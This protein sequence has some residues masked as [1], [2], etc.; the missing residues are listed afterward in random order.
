[1]KSLSLLLFF[2]ATC[3]SAQTNQVTRPAP[4]VFLNVAVI[5]TG[6]ASVQRNMTV[7]IIEDHIAEMGSAAKIK[8]PKNAL[9]VEGRG[10]FVIPGLW[11]MHAHVLTDK[12]EILL[13]MLVAN[14][15]TGVREMG[16]DSDVPIPAM[17]AIRKT[18]K[19]GGL[20][21]PYV[22]MAGHILDGPKPVLP[23]N[24]AIHSEQEARQTVVELKDSGVDFI[25]VY[26][27]LPRG[28]YF[29]IADEAKKQGLPFVGHVPISVTAEE[30]SDAG[31]KEL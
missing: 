5:D 23:T 13:P 1:M 20:I 19:E 29:A 25:K 10:K 16:N 11:D 6:N 24:V 26:T 14:G 21:G 17:D 30:A 7:V 15:V 12:A 9:V 27:G 18:V 22:L 4:I 31:Q 3:A 28:L 2:L 8:L